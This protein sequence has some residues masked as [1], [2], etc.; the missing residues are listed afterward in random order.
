MNAKSLGFDAFQREP[1][2]LNGIRLAI[3]DHTASRLI[4]WPFVD[5][6]RKA[7]KIVSAHDGL[8]QALEKLIADVEDVAGGTYLNYRLLLSER[9]KPAR[10]A[11]ARA[12]G[13]A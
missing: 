6:L 8:V 5:A 3:D 1:S 10:A 7:D 4:D 11:L 13:E 2:P 9:L 12:K